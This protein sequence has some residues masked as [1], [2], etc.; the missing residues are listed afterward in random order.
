MRATGTTVLFPTVIGSPYT[1]LTVALD[2]NFSPI[3]LRI[4][5]IL[6]ELF[7]REFT[8]PN[9]LL[10]P[11]T[12]SLIRKRIRPD[13]EMH[14]FAGCSFAGFAMKR[15]ASAPGR[16]DSFTFPTGIWIV[17]TP[18]HSLSE[19]AKRIRN[20]HDDELT[21]YQ[22]NQRIRGVAGDNRRVFSETQ[23]IE[24]IDPVIVV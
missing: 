15:S 22:R 18:V 1:F 11:S 14:D 3:L 24:L 12:D 5:G 20:T 13:L 17:D 19:E 4:S 9:A 23:C 6:I 16:P 8:Y 10:R 7:S 21:V 2:A